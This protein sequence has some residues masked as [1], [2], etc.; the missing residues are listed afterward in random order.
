MQNLEN[1]EKPKLVKM[2]P[3][4]FPPAL[5]RIQL[6]PAATGCCSSRSCLS[7][8]PT[9]ISRIYFSWGTAVLLL[10]FQKELSPSDLYATN[11]LDSTKFCTFKLKEALHH[12]V[13]A[14]KP[15]PLHHAVAAGKPRPSLCWAYMRAFGRPFWCSAIC[16]P[17]WLC[18]NIIQ[19]FSLRQI[20]VFVSNNGRTGSS[21]EQTMWAVLSIAGFCLGALCQPLLINHMFIWS[22]RVGL[23]ARAATTGLIW[24]RLSTMRS[25]ELNSQRGATIMNL[26]EVDSAFSKWCSAFPYVDV[27]FFL[28]LSLPTCQCSLS[29]LFPLSFL[30]LSLSLS[31]FLSL[32]LSFSLS[33]SLQPCAL[34]RAFAMAT[35]HG[36]G[37]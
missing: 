6:P 3:T 36:L 8:V 31:L 29:S 7:W 35:L 11:Q 28:F 25:S 19:I 17:I 1:L 24:E 34:S 18:F 16:R 14:G 21:D 22:L 23:R 4:L 10:G 9:L 27:F 5:P 37:F 30:S 33:L 12:A 32:F 26:A 20:L 15:R 13:A 2:L